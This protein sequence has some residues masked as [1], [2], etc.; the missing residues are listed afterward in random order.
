MKL[1]RPRESDGQ[2]SLRASNAS[3]APSKPGERDTRREYRIAML[4]PQNCSHALTV[5]LAADGFSQETTFI[6][7]TGAS[8]NL[9]KQRNI[10][11]ETNIRKTDKLYLNGITKD[12]IES[13]GSIQAHYMGYPLELHVVNNNFPISQEGILENDFLRDASSI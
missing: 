3:N 6:V 5:A 12:K 8:S 2:R 4:N 10:H 11:P 1:A 9:V 7:D 13:L